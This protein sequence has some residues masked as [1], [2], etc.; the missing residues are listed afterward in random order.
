MPEEILTFMV[1]DAELMFKNFSGEKSPYNMQG[2][3]TFC[4]MLDEVAAKEMS[5]IGWNV[6]YLASREEGEADRPYIQV[7]ARF[8][9]RPPKITMITSRARTRLTEDMVGILDW[10]DIRKCDLIARA[11]NWTVGD[12]SGIKAYLQTMFVTVLE[13][14]LELKYAIADGED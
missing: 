11:H 6:K 8:D 9:I 7:T 5:E 2:E 1:E 14:E 13:D 10:A 3:R 4:V 12:K